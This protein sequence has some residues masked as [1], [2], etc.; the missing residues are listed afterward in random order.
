MWAELE[1]LMGNR[2][3]QK[4]SCILIF[5]A[6][7]L[8]AVGTTEYAEEFLVFMMIIKERLGKATIVLPLPPILLGGC[9][10]PDLLR[11]MFEL[12][13]WTEDLS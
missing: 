11:N 8:A 10:R 2:R 4:G 7:H 9:N 3:V 5:S 13:S 1:K 6:S 12:I